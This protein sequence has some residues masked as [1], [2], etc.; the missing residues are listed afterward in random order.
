MIF[1]ASLIVSVGADI[2]GDWQGGGYDSGYTQEGSKTE[3][4]HHFQLEAN[5]T[6]SGAAADK[7]LNVNCKP[8]A[9]VSA[10]I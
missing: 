1:K 7:R 3:R 4:C 9:S 2:L 6:L 8:K 10:Y 5:M